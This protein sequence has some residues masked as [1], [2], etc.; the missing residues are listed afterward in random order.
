MVS[1]K[2]KVL[3]REESA[4]ILPTIWHCSRDLK[5]SPRFGFEFK[6]CLFIK[7]TGLNAIRWVKDF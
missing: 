6:N 2:T 1:F 3:S 4:N 7:R 5:V